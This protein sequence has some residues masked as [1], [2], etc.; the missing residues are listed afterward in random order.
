MCMHAG[1]HSEIP[2][3]GRGGG[4]IM[5]CLYKRGKNIGDAMMFLWWLSVKEIHVFICE[6]NRIVDIFITF[7]ISFQ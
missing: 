3:R 2:S 7:M 4:K 5:I 6:T 1:F